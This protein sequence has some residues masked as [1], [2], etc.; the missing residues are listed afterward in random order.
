LILATLAASV[1]TAVLHDGDASGQPR[2]DPRSAAA[3]D[4]ASHQPR[5]VAIRALLH[6]RSTAV[7]RHDRAAFLSTVDPREK[8]F[9]A[10]QS[11]LF[12][13]L[14]AVHFAGWSYTM[15]R[16]SAGRD[17]G[18]LLAYAAPAWA[19]AHFA[20][21]YRLAGFDPS[22]TRLPQYPTFV[23]RTGRWY[24]ASLSDFAWR[25]EV[26]A[27]DLWDYGPVKVVH[28]GP[29]LVLGALQDS[30]T[31][32]EVAA[33]ARNAIPKVTAVWGRWSQRAVIRIPSTQHEMALITGDNGGLDRIAAVASAEVQSSHGRPA[34]VGNRITINPQAWPD[35]GAEGASVVLT[36]ELTHVATRADTGTQTPRWLAEGFA[37]YVGFRGSGL[38]VR[39]IAAE[40]AR[41][42]RHGRLPLRL[43]TDADFGGRARG[44]NRAYELS[45]MACRY[46]AKRFGQADLVRFY[47]QVGRSRLRTGPAVASALHRVLGLTPAQFT[48]GWRKTVERAFG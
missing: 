9:Y 12:A 33:L 21:H 26:S 39:S 46:L 37:D 15:S 5:Q 45:W 16:R 42:V 47:R 19:P 23:E 48:L 32:Y 8:A 35:L 44:L 28:S 24:L 40:L 18:K 31:M 3:L 2:A 4:P 27:T 13:N 14:A 6:R 10:A 29:V 22:P 38:S 11:Q 17:G 43:P 7:L 36:H 34:P 30:D 20:L 25:G 41:A 1:T